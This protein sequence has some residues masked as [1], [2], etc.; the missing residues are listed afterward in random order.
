LHRRIEELYKS[1]ASKNG[2]CQSCGCDL[3]GNVSGI[4]PEFGTPIPDQPPKDALHR[5]LAIR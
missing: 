5:P 3:T 4:C 1:I 2:R